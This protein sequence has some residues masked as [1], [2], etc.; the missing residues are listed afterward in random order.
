MAKWSDDANIVKKVAAL[1]TTNLTSIQIACE[2]G[3]SRH[4]FERFIK[5]HGLSNLATRRTK[6]LNEQKRYKRSLLNGGEHERQAA[7]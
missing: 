2:L 4:A 7:R 6:I 1:L 5:R 3:V